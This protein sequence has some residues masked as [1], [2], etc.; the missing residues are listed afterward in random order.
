MGTEVPE[1]VILTEIEKLRSEDVRYEG[2]VQRDTIEP[3][4]LCKKE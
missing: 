3:I 1:K 4:V 2:R